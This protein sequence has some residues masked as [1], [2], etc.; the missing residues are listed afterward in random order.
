M[1]KFQSDLGDSVELNT[2]LTIDDSVSPPRI[3]SHLDTRHCSPT[4]ATRADEMVVRTL[5]EKRGKL[6]IGISVKNNF[7]HRIADLTYLAIAYLRLFH[8]MGYEWV[9][10]PVGQIV[11]KQLADPHIAIARTHRIG[12]E[13][14]FDFGVKLALCLADC[15]AKGIYVPIPPTSRVPQ[16]SAVWLPLFHEI[17]PSHLPTGIEGYKQDITTYRSAH[18]TLSDPPSF[19]YW[20]GEMYPGMRFAWSANL[21]VQGKDDLKPRTIHLKGG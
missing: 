3:N 20:H 14:P 18:E 11:R 4:Q 15:N 10:S 6:S 19:L 9:L 17:Y 16:A 5:T 21:D 12:L 8:E 2:F 13:A 7:S 1:T